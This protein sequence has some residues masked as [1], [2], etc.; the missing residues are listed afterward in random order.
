MIAWLWSRVEP[1]CCGVLGVLLSVVECCG[2]CWL[3]TSTPKKSLVISKKS[4]LNSKKSKKNPKK[5]RGLGPK[6][7]V[8]NGRSKTAC[9]TS[10]QYEYIAYVSTSPPTPLIML[11]D[12]NNITFT[13]VTSPQHEWIFLLSVNM[14]HPYQPP[15]PIH[16]YPT[17]V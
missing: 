13:C 1:W 4:H 11:I 2:L 7:A 3:V 8:K 16:S 12:V 14:W 17:F 5:F 15:L 9:V 6:R 10:P